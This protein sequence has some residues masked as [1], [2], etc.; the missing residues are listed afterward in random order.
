M[1]SAQ[2]VNAVPFSFLETWSRQRKETSLFSIS[3]RQRFV[4]YDNPEDGSGVHLRVSRSQSVTEKKTF[5]SLQVW[6]NRFLDFGVVLCNF[7]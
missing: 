4:A 1:Q 2:S 3:R 5:K 7:G 6:Q